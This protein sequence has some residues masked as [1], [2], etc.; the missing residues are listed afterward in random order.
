[1]YSPGAL[2]FAFTVALPL[3]TAGPSIFSKTG[4]RLSNVTSPG[5][6][7]FV[8]CR[9]TAGGGLR[10]G[11]FDP[12]EYF[13]SSY[14]HTGS[15]SPA[16]IVAVRAMPLATMPIGPWMV[17]PVASNLITGGLLPT[18]MSVNGLTS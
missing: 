2:N 7:Y 12:L 9:M 6:R 1:M 8:Q 16:A 13:A 10:C 5:P 3:N 18:A 15:V 11:A 4:F 14:A 17:G